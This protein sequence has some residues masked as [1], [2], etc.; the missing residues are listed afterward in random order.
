MKSILPCFTEERMKPVVATLAAVL[1]L[2]PVLVSVTGCTGDSRKVL[3]REKL[4]SLSYGRFEDEIDLF[5]LDSGTSGPDTQVFMRDGLVYIA[6]SGAKKILQFTSYGDLLSVYYN[7]ETNPVPSFAG[8]DPG[9]GTVTATTRKAVAYPFNHPVYLSVDLQKRLF[10]ADQLPRERFEFDSEQRVILR[11]VVLRFNPDGQF[12][13]FLGQEGPGGTP[14]PPITALYTNVRNEL[15]V[16][17]KTPDTTIVFWFDR[18]GSLLYQVPVSVNAL[19]SFYPDGEKVMPTLDRIVM[20]Q[21]QVRLYMKIDYYTPIIDQSTGADAG[22]AYDASAIYPFDIDKGAYGE[23][24]DVP[25]YEG[26]DKDSQGTFTYKKPYELLGVTSGQWFFFCTPVDE[27]YLLEAL[28]S[29]TSRV[30]QRILYVSPDELAYNALILSDDGILTALLA[31]G[32]NA[33]VVWWRT[34][35][36]FGD[37]R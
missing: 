34:D 35:S 25:F 1:F 21:N 36:L 29:K 37:I 6:N 2:F 4:F 27:G 30:H 33:S 18:D 15:V 31:S 8:A 22:I 26:V 3:E 9:D 12:L 10:V 14:F 23:R 20:D 24:I 7:P 17:S 11:D 16:I 19:P 13:D 5:N 32:L 28:D